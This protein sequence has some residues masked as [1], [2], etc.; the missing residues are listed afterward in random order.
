MPGVDDMP[1]NKGAPPEKVGEKGGESLNQ[2][3]DQVGEAARE[4]ASE[5][6]GG[7]ASA[8]QFIQAMQKEE[9]R[10][11]EKED[12][13]VKI[14]RNYLHS[15]KYPEILEQV[16]KLLALNVY[17]G[18]LVTAL[19]LID[20]DLKQAVIRQSLPAGESAAAADPEMNKLPTYTRFDSKNI[21]PQ[22]RENLESWIYSLSE[23]ASGHPHRFLEELTDSNK[24]ADYEFQVLLRLVTNQ[25]FTEHAIQAELS[26]IQQFAEF[27][28]NGITD[29]LLK[30]IEGQKEIK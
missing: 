20:E 10:Q 28:F 22:V 24:Q 5:S 23:V 26:E 15:N 29:K 14:L 7:F 8:S 27:I 6:W 3:G 4:T 13:I 16:V 11:R 17:A 21:P 19:I 12:E 18:F 9:G 25:F 1:F 30:Q 2:A